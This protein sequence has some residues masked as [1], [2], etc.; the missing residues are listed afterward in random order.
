MKLNFSIA[1]ILLNCLA[2]AQSVGPAVM[3]SN[4]LSG[5][6]NN[7]YFEFNLG[8]NFTSTI[9]S[10][11]FITQGL[12]QPDGMMGGPLPVTGLDLQARRTGAGSVQLNWKT[13]QEINNKGF[14]IERKKEHEV[15]FT[16]GTFI[17]SAAVN[18][19]ASLPIG[20]AF[21]DTNS[22]TGKTYY[23]L[24]QVDIDGAFAYSPIRMVDGIE[25][26]TASLK[27]WPVPSNGTINITVE[28]IDKDIL[29]FFDSNGR[30]VKQQSVSNASTQQINNLL[31]G[32]YI[33]RLTGKAT[34][35][36]KIIVQ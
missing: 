31:P 30:L 35:V 33:L 10:G 19:N 32:V 20:Y 13:L 36:Q 9:G 21:T 4:G 29:Q 6:A 27:V 15:N 34:A 25:N 3:N 1:F 17:N 5:I 28:G 11:P 8:E 24:K 2:N 22:Y 18:G 26:K 12:L 16:Q 7:I 14:Y 23:R